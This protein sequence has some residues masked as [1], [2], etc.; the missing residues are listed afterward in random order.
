MIFK[1][2]LKSVKFV[3]AQVAGRTYNHEHVS[4]FEIGAAG[5][6]IELFHLEIRA[7][8]RIGYILNGGGVGRIVRL[9]AV[10]G[11]QIDGSRLLVYHKQQGV[12]EPLL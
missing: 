2:G 4:L 12:C 6:Q 1:E 7:L 8:E 10:P 9:L 11:E 3:F 5:N